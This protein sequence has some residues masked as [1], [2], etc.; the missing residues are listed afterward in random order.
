MRLNHCGVSSWVA[1]FWHP[2]TPIPAF[3]AT[4]L[5][6]LLGTGTRM[7]R[8]AGIIFGGQEIA[9]NRR[10]DG[11]IWFSHSFFMAVFK[12]LSC[13]NIPRRWSLRYDAKTVE[14]DWGVEAAH[15]GYNSLS[16]PSLCLSFSLFSFSSLPL[17][18]FLSV[19]A[20]MC[21]LW[22][23][24]GG[25]KPTRRASS[26]ILPCLRQGLYLPIPGPWISGA[27]PVIIPHPHP[28]GWQMHV[29][30]CAWG[31]LNLGPHACAAIPPYPTLAFRSGMFCIWYLFYFLKIASHYAA[32]S[33]LRH[34]LILLP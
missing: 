4:T 33:H 11:V 20:G 14:G 3:W 15:G 26:H 18:C 7:L 21:I 29:L 16:L 12:M 34:V 27:S 6:F 24:C 28:T 5:G 19:C 32:L 30:L 9:L 1:F 17:P 8:C 31:N 13:V 23:A 25:Q 2:E 22:H 10:F